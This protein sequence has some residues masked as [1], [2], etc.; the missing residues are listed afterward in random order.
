MFLYFA[1]G[2]V[3]KYHGSKPLGI[4]PDTYIKAIDTS[5]KVL[6][7]TFAKKYIKFPK[8]E[9]ALKNAK[10]AAKRYKNQ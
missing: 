10:L 9:E 2:D 7:K 8:K 4:S 6:H 3:R 1:S 5:I